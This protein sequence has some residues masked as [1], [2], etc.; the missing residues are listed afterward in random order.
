[1]INI[2]GGN[3]FIGQRYCDLTTNILKNDREDYTV[4][5]CSQ[6]LYFISTVDNYNIFTNPY[7]DIDTNLT[8]LIKVLESCKDKNIVFNFISSWFVYGD[9]A[10]PAREDSYCDPK[11]FYSITK[12]AAEQLLISYCETFGIKYRILRLANVLGKT[13]SKVS[14][15]K[16]ALQ[17]LI[18][19]LKQ[20]NELKLY[21]GGFLFRDYI[22]VD[23]AVSAINL[24]LEK[25]DVNSIYNVGNGKAIYLID[26]LNKSKSL[27]NSDSIFTSVEQA[28]F[29]KI[30][31][32]KNMVLDIDKLKNLGYNQ[33]YSIDDIIK[34]LIQ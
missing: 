16:N 11:G 31:Q 23:D 5:D 3:G 33:K 6:V 9:V 17:Y 12:R 13:D 18:S 25:G 1:M 27:L 30:V 34:I 19:E 21:D 8:T 32:T 22:Y 2:F 7:I 28:D 29:H 24:I 15:K 14:K 20:N 26:I 4:K 10:L